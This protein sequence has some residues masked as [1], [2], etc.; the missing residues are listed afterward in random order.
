MVVLW[1]VLPEVPVMVKEYVPAGVPPPLGVGLGLGF[2]VGVGPACVPDP[3]LQA[4]IT[5][6]TEARAGIAIQ[7]SRCR[8]FRDKHRTSMPAAKVANRNASHNR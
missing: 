5:R 2:G 1:V 8:G 6:R 3:P 7:R 4:A